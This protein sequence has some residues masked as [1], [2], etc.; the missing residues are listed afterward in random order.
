M[1]S[2]IAIAASGC[3]SRLPVIDD[4]APT[5]PSN[6]VVGDPPPPLPPVPAA[7]VSLILS[8]AAVFSGSGATGRVVLSFPASTPGLTVALSSGDAAVVVPT[9]ISVAAGATSAEFPIVT[10]PLSREITVSIGATSGERAVQATLALWFRTPPFIASWTDPGNGQPIDGRRVTKSALAWRASCRGSGVFVGAFE[11]PTS[12]SLD[13]S[14]PQGTALIPGTYEN[15][16]GIVRPLSPTLPTLQISAPGFSS[17]AAP[18]PSRFTVTEA[19]LIADQLGTV[20]RFTATFEQGCRL[21]ARSTTIRGEVVV[22]GIAPTNVTDG[23]RC[24]VPR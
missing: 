18:E 1:V 8:P 23:T 19:D 2:A 5:A 22:V 7:L 10:S 9:S 20:R 24:I 12:Y 17:C 11:G 15:A 14:A 3:N 6:V 13:F 21:A 16:Q 4:T